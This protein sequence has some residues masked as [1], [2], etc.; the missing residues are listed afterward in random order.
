MR[1][2]SLMVVLGLLA[3]AGGV[4]GQVTTYTVTAETGQLAE[5]PTGPLGEAVTITLPVPEVP[6]SQAFVEL[7]L[8][9]SGTTQFIAGEHDG[10][11]QT[12]A[13]FGAV[14]ADAQL[15]LLDL[16]RAVLSARAQ[17]RT[18]VTLRMEGVG[19]PA[20]ALDLLPLDEAQTLA[21]LVCVEPPPVGDQSVAVKSLGRVLVHP[22][23][24]SGALVGLAV[25]PNP[26]NPRATFALDLSAAEHVIIT[27]FDLRGRRIRTVLAQEVPAGRQEASWDGYD[28]G[29]RLV[30]AGTYL[31]QVRV[32][33]RTSN[34]K[35]A[36][37][38]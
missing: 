1:G 38:R 13:G 23:P 33:S 24:A 31:Y 14:P 11:W 35:I 17:G 16:S 3:T 2:L 37:I 8:A 36:V 7:K 29:G 4:A 27:I 26:T 18:E 30:S 34:G 20:V 22:D 21:R 10:G 6:L 5:I 9:V 12:V 32:G 28:G 25:Y 19:S 15:L